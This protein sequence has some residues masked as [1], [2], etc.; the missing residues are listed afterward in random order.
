MASPDQPLS[1]LCSLCASIFTGQ[2]IDK[3]LGEEAIE[4][5]C[6]TLEQLKEAAYEKACHFCLL[7]YRTFS[8]KE[9]KELE[10]CK[11]VRFG[12][13]TSRVGK[14]VAFDYYYPRID[15]DRRTH[16]TK[17]V[18]FGTS[19]GRRLSELSFLEDLMWC[20]LQT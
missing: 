4:P 7:R 13:W 14:G 3:G 17:S 12:F 16:A 10:G 1:Q 9:L 20:V 5:F 2:R 11:H 15:P 18:L 8:Y 6:Q 19:Q